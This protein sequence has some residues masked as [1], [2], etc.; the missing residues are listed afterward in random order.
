M[1]KLSHMVLPFALGLSMASAA[2]AQTPPA[3]PK[4]E[5][6][7]PETMQ[8]LQ[9]GRIA[10]I[11]GALKMTDAQ[12][13]LWAPV[14]ANIR[15]R[16]AARTKAMETWGQKRQAGA[17]RPD[18]PARMERMAQMMTERAERTK[19]FVAV[20]KPFYESLTDEQKTVVGPLMARMEGGH[21]G[22]HRGGWAMNHRR[23]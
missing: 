12:Q 11:T 18:L 17:E 7:S 5:R 16:Q 2:F 20:F 23:G 1:K 22:G 6:P 19:A 13:K 21:K 3:P 4:R 10:M 14:E 8:R 15:E 9:D